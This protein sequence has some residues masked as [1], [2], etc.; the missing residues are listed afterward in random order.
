MTFT[1]GADVPEGSTLGA[2]ICVIG[3]GPAGL[4]IAREFVGSGARVIVLES[5]ERGY[6]KSLRSPLRVLRQ[7]T[8]GAQSLSAGP[9]RGQPYSLLRFSR[10][11]AFGGSTNAL[12]GHGLQTRPFDA[13]DFEQR[14]GLPLS[15]WPF[16]LDHL[17]PYYARAATL[18]GLDDGAYG[19]A[20]WEPRIGAS[21][22][23][24]DPSQLE[25]TYF[26]YAPGKT[27]ASYGDA[28]EAYSEIEVITDATATAL[29]ASESRDRLRHVGVRSLSG[30]QFSVSAP[31]F[32][33]AGGALE[34]AKL[35]LFGDGE[36]GAPGLG[37]QND[38][39]GRHFMEHPQ[40]EVGH[41]LP[42]AVAIDSLAGYQR[43]E[44]GGQTVMPQLRLPDALL[45]ARDLLNGS[46]ELYAG[47]P[48]MARS[49][50][51]AVRLL[52]RSLDHKNR[53]NGLGRAL[54]DSVLAAP[55]VIAHV[56]SGRAPATAP[57]V[58]IQVMAEQEPNP[59]SRVRLSGREDRLGVRRVELDWQ[60]TARDFDSIRRSADALGDALS[61]AGLGEMASTL[62]SQNSDVPVFGNWHHMGTTR[63][64][65]DPARGVV[66]RD[67]RL[68]ALDNVY[69]AG[70]SVFPTGGTSNPTLTLVALALRLADH[71]L[72]RTPPAD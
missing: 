9:T 19:Q 67:S 22:L 36:A 57:L 6:T 18:A 39:V 71:L 48:T 47:R 45:R 27:F 38:M 32:V 28:F 3:A 53:V 26:R 33:L 56:R 62:P 44:I 63:M 65:A 11:R 25:T 17:A 59:E 49:G 16:D 13:I 7:H 72:K 35:L 51:R 24:V 10:A 61:T 50:V 15:G 69:V 54:R 8:R 1:R 70:S 52:K 4:A 55:D 30:N 23:P 66:D 40:V 41:W 42:T 64:D 58:E 20:V 29:V 46:Y 43:Q 31:T 60:L 12:V 21:P 37:N 5:G 14:P 34:N 68:H 2:D